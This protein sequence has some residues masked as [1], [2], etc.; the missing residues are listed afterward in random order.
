[1]ALQYQLTRI[2]GW[3]ELC[4]HAALEDDP[5][6]GIKKGDRVMT[7]F[8]EALIMF[9]MVVD[10]G[11]ITEKNYVDFFDRLRFY[12]LLHGR[13]LSTHADFDGPKLTS[14][15]DVK[16]YIGLSTNVSFQPEVKWR[17][18]IIDHYFADLHRKRSW[19]NN[20]SAAEKEP[21]LI[22]ALTE[23]RDRYARENADA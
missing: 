22:D 18:R 5:H 12:E 16:R 11:E 9:T 10:M 19:D 14:L 3:Q 13:I 6:R 4:F 23:Y 1:M 21:S 15:E 20:V 7:P 2:N 17:K 8:T